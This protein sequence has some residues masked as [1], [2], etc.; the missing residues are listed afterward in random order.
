MG[1]DPV[2]PLL[3]LDNP[4]GVRIDLETVVDVT[5]DLRVT[6]DGA[7]TV[8]TGIAPLGE[9]ATSTHGEGDLVSGTVKLITD[10]PISGMLRLDLPDVGE[11]IVG[12]GTP[13]GDAVL[14]VR[15]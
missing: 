4:D 2:R 5:G 8:P 3:Y 7:L 10:G 14:P 11:A 12:V 1:S 9:L 13:T 6:D 15:R